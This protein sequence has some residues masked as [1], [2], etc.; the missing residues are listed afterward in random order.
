[1]GINKRKA[2]LIA[3][4]QSPYRK[5]FKVSAVAPRD[6]SIGAQEYFVAFVNVKCEGKWCRFVWEKSYAS[7]TAWA[8]KVK[9][10]K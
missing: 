4:L 9:M 6:T 10:Q 2:A 5:D 8:L 7:K 3:S 1:M